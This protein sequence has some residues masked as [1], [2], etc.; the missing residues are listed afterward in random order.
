MMKKIIIPVLA[1]TLIMI[2][3]SCEKSEDP[4]GERGIAIVP[5][6]STPN[7]GF[8]INGDEDSYI[9]FDVD[10]EGVTQPDKTEVVVSHGTNF[11][12]VKIADVS[13]FPSTFTFTLGSILDAIGIGLSE[14]NA[15]D[16]IY[17]EVET[18]LDTKVTRSS[19]SLAIPV[20]CA[21][22][23]A[24]A[25]GEYRAASAS[26]GVDGSVTLAADPADPY[27][28]Y[29]SGLAELDGLVEDMGPFVMQIDA[30][31]LRVTGAKQVLASEC[32]PYHNFAYEITSPGSF[33]TCDGKYSMYF[34]IT[35]TEGSWGGPWAFT[36]TR[37]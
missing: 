17:V 34:G 11:E 6:V 16:I 24:L 31:T 26:W 29:I 21:F 7:P 36:L 10:L 12:R 13:T 25:V 27:K 2:C 15:G 32:G 4:A 5:S 23:P 35:V 8:F 30:A 14:I 20:V 18:T 22:D 37:K 28:I 3:F 19:A 1:I 33:N 9:R